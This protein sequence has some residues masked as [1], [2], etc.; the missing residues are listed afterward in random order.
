MCCRD[1]CG[2]YMYRMFLIN[3]LWLF[4]F[5]KIPYIYLDIDQC[6]KILCLLLPEAN[7]NYEMKR[8]YGVTNRKYS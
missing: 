5:Q 6:P 8:F 2:C 3:Y 7:Q 4:N 1:V